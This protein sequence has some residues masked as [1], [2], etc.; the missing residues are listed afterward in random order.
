[1]NY[2]F[3]VKVINAHFN[4]TFKGTAAESD[5]ETVKNFSDNDDGGEQGSDSKPKHVPVSLHFTCHEK[6]F[7][8]F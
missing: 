5:V 1:M 4:L 6:I 8:I 2:S 7:S 3:I